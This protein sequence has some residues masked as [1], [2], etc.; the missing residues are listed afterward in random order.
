MT[1]KRVTIT[2][3]MSLATLAIFLVAKDSQAAWGDPGGKFCGS[4]ANPC[5]PTGCVNG[6]WTLTSGGVIS[7][8]ASIKKTLVNSHEKCSGYTE[9]DPKCKE[10][11]QYCL[12]V[13]MY[14]PAN[15]GGDP[16]TSTYESGGQKC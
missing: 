14:G 2:L 5:T 3:F 10:S 7:S 13:L 15:C 4:M 6:V 16:V 11:T 9:P 1:R 8:G 12:E